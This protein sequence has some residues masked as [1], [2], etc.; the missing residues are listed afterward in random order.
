MYYRKNATAT[1]DAAGNFNFGDITFNKKGT[2]TFTV[3]EVVPA[4]EDKIP[5][6]AYDADPVTITVHVTD[7]N[8]GTN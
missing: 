5:G 8:N 7:N 6:V 2:Y 4:E 3:S 1:S